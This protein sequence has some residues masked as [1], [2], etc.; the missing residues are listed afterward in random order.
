MIRVVMF[1]LGRTL[2]DDDERPFAHVEDALAAISAF[3]T[4]AGEAFRF[5]LV[6]DF[7]MPTAPPTAAKIA[8]LFEEF[9]AILDRTGLRRFFEPVQRR[10]TLSTHAGVAKPARST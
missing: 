9:L 7:T 4:P 1:D 8:A 2:I 6:S 3:T 5:C 10:V